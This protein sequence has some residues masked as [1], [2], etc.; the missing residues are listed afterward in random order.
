M[1]CVLVV[2]FLSSSICAYK[3]PNI[4]KKVELPEVIERD[5]A[6]T[7][8]VKKSIIGH[9]IRKKI[10]DEVADN[11]E[12]LKTFDSFNPLYIFV[13]I[14]S[15]LLSLNDRRQSKK[16]LILQSQVS[17]PIKR[18]VDAF[19]LVLVIILMRNVKNAI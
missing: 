18:Y 11:G 13:L 2:I 4:P 6:I 15:S 17:N 3:L 1:R 14:T 12:I 8:I 5:S 10:F 7:T 9:S 19:V 16:I